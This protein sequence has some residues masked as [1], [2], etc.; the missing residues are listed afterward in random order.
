MRDVKHV[1]RTLVIGGPPKS[2]E[3]FDE[4]CKRTDR[5]PG[6]MFFHLLA[7]LTGYCTPDTHDGPEVERLDCELYGLLTK[8]LRP[9]AESVSA[10]AG[11]QEAEGLLR[12]P[13]C[14]GR[15]GAIWSPA[16]GQL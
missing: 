5:A 7:V 9:G 16:A 10:A 12:C 3:L 13:A 14:A 1:K 4:L 2:W 6:M 15:G 11:R 8:A